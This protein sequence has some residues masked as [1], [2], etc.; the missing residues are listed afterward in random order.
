MSF[1]KKKKDVRVV[2]LTNWLDWAGGIKSDVFVAL[3]M[4]QRGSVW[5]PHQIIDLWD[6][7]LQG[8]PIGSLMAS[9]LKPGTKVRRLGQSESKA[10]DSNGGLGLIDGQ[11]R[12]LA[13]LAAWSLANEIK[14]DR[15]VWIDFA[16]NPPPGQLFRLRVTTVNQ[17]FG[18]RTDE[19]SSKLSLHDRR[20]AQDL[21]ELMQKDKPTLENAWPYTSKPTIPID[22]RWLINKWRGNDPTSWEKIVLEETAKIKSEREAWH[23]SS[24]DNEIIKKRVD[25]LNKALNRLFK[26]EVPLI[27]VD[28]RFFEID[29]NKDSDPPLALLFKRIGTG[30][31]E[32]SNADYVYSI[33]KHLRPE[34]HDLVESLYEPKDGQCNVSRLLTATDLVMSAV[35]LAAVTGLLNDS[36]SLGK[37]EFQ[38]LLRQG[39]FLEDSFLPLIKAKTVGARETEKS[40]I[41]QYFLQIQACLKYKGDG[42]IGLPRHMFP[43]LGRPLV[44]VLLR[45]AQA[46]YLSDLNV[47]RR[48]DVLR[49]VLFWILSVKDHKK[50]SEIAYKV[51]KERNGEYNQI[52][53]AIHAALISKTIALCLVEPDIIKARPNLAI[54]LNDKKLCN[55]SRFE[56]ATDNGNQDEK[57]YAHVYEL[58][59]RW[60]RPWTYHHPMLLWLQREYVTKKENENYWPDPMAGREDDTPYDYDHLLP[61]SNWNDWRGPSGRPPSFSGGNVGVIGNGI[62]N[63]RVWDSSDNR[64]DGDKAPKTKLQITPESNDD[65]LLNEQN[66]T[67]AELLKWSAIPDS[68]I[69]AGQKQQWVNCSPESDKDKRNWDNPHR[70]MAFQRAVELRTFYLYERFYRELGFSAWLEPEKNND[71]K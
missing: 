70:T 24:S 66:P 60:W 12:T 41:V 22:L 63:V 56:P 43:H 3:P 50:A 1:F 2:P 17:P 42:D 65:G 32:L 68:N 7:L 15:R 51:I 37:Q 48:H 57:Q 45:L 21:Y 40:P 25:E 18:F 19:P 14:M 35:R 71:P 10:V 20:K 9:E 69:D 53:Y 31:T 39:E 59:Q 64:K 58:Y 49:L 34:T 13:M 5:K 27:R 55:Y 11:Q 67:S 44:Q 36:E 46:G 52:G 47:E 62:G 4:I 16:D 54:S 28:D 6:S 8:M 61:S 30:G 23:T 26:M 38:R 29:D 33:I